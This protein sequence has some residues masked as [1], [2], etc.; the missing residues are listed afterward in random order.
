MYLI[1]LM[2]S[3][4]V[5]SKAMVLLFLIHCCSQYLWGF[6]AGC[7]FCYA[8]LSALSSYLSPTAGGIGLLLSV[9]LN[10]IFENLK[11]DS[12]QQCII[13]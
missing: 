5:C 11:I 13:L 10:F 3:A 6:C 8:V 9:R 1:P 4:A 2:A 12:I 7:L